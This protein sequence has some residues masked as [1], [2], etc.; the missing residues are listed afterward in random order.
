MKTNQQTPSLHT[1]I[2][3]ITVLFFAACGQMDEGGAAADGPKSKI[4]EKVIFDDSE[5][6]VT[7][8]RDLGASLNHE[9]LDNKT[10]TGKFILV[11]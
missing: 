11:E 3:A 1:I 10:T 2:C 8:A 4:G 9:F 7:S 6:V 5:W